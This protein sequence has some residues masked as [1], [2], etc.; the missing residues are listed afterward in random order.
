MVNFLQD[1]IYGVTNPLSQLWGAFV[2][3]LPSIIVAVLVILVGAFVAVIL[4]HALRILL[5]RLRVDELLRKAQLTKAVG[6]TDVPALLGELLK[7]WIIIIALQ[8]AVSTLELG[9]LSDILGSFVLWLP[10]LLVAVVI[11]L[12]GLSAAHYVEIK[13]MEHTRLKG[14]RLTAKILKWVILILVSVQALDLIGLDVSLFENLILYVIVA[15]AAG[16][17][18]A[19]GIALGLGLRK[20]A[21]NI[22]KDVKKD[23]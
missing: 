10:K 2:T 11:M 20:E 9:S 6:H 14:M 8:V 15:L 13:I 21:E 17:A 18:L 23:L 12:L 7:W 16:I 4:G 22:I 1:T 3:V 5:D 19:L